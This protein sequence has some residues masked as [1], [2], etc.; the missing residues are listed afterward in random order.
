MIKTYNY[1]NVLSNNYK[2]NAKKRVDSLIKSK[3]YYKDGPKYQTYPNLHEYEDFVLFKKTFIKSC[4]LY[5]NQEVYIKNIRMWCYVDCALNNCK[6]KLNDQWHNHDDGQ[7]KLS[8]IFYLRNLRKETTEF[9]KFGKL[10]YNADSWYVYPSFLMHRPP[11]IN[12]FRNRYTIAA[13]LS[14]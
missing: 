5:L 9:E 13:D 2:N 8:G 12:S 11:K 3:N 10:H 4:F 7:Y 1:S 14:F 6:K